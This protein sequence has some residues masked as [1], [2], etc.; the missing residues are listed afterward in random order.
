MDLVLRQIQYIST[1]KKKV[2]NMKTM[3]MLKLKKFICTC[4]EC[5][6]CLHMKLH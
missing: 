2:A 3:F 4:T 1:G 5:S 6:N